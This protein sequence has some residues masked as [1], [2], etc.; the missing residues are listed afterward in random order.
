MK[1]Q[2]TKRQKESER[3][4]SSPLNSKLSHSEGGGVEADRWGGAGGYTIPKLTV[5]LT[6]P[7]SNSSLSV[8]AESREVVAM[9]SP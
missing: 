2:Y 1:R 4:D 8:S 7:P 3:W 9:R 6:R 5:S